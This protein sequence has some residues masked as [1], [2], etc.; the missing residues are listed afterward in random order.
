MFGEH[1]EK[2]N[3]QRE[4]KD[5]KIRAGAKKKKEKKKHNVVVFMVLHQAE[6]GLL[7]TERAG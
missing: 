7:N 2:K 1:R 4:I 5:K 6:K 3:S